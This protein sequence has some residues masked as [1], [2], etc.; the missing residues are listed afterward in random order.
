MKIKITRVERDLPLPDYHTEGAVAFDFYSRVDTTLA[1]REKKILPSNFIIEVPVGHVLIVAA[2]SGTPKKGIML[3]NNIGLI[4]QDYHG[5][6]DEIGIWVWN[7][8]DAPIEIK[9]GDRIA[10]GLIVP[11][12]RAEFEEVAQIKESSRGGFGSTG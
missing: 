4:D 8:T 12:V 2:R 3:A 6:A 5:P 10:Q 1:P 9:R 7:F 11:I